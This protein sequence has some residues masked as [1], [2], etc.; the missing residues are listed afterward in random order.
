MATLTTQQTI[1][2]GEGQTLLDIAMQ[3]C[4]DVTVCLAIAELN[5]KSISDLLT[6]GEQLLV[7][8]PDI[9]KQKIVDLFAQKGLFPASTEDGQLEQFSGIDYWAIDVDFIVQ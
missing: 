4:G 2:V 5:G 7:P 9:S 6:T 1:K 3:Y 8:V